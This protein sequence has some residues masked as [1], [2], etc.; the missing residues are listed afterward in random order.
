MH[1]W[2]GSRHSAFSDDLTE[3]P[4]T[5][6]IASCECTAMRISLSAASP[7]LEKLQPD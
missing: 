1:A 6:F 7:D 3:S 5:T 4:P 2:W